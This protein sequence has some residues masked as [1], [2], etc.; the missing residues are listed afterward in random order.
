MAEMALGAAT[1]IGQRRAQLRRRPP[2][3]DVLAIGPVPVE[4]FDRH[5]KLAARGVERKRLEQAG[6]GVGTGGMMAEGVETGP[7]VATQNLDGK[8]DEV[9]GRAV[10]IRFEVGE[11][12]HRLVVE[13]ESARLDD[14]L[15]SL[16][17][18]AIARHGRQQ[19]G[20]HRV[21]FGLS[22]ARPA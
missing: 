13:V 22:P 19:G 5:E 16:R 7:V 6:N 11:S 20:R 14:R 2:R 3:H 1:Q 21:A 4:Q 17:R 15:Q 10:G 18:Q 8:G 12:R 9:S